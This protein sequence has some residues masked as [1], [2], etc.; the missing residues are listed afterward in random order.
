MDKKTIYLFF[1]EDSYTGNEKLKLWKKEFI[2]KYG[3]DGVEVFSESKF[4]SNSFATNIE[5]VPFLSEKKLII[6]KDF[7]AKAKKED[8]EKLSKAIE[9]TPDFCIL[10]F[11]E[12]GSID[13]RLGLYKKISK[14]GT[15][16]EFKEKNPSEI[17]SFILTKARREEIKISPLV[18]NYIST[19]CGSDLW[20][21]SNEIKKLKL[22]AQDKEVTT[23]MVDQLTT[24]SLS[25][26]V[27]KLT[28]TITEKDSRKALQILKTLDENGEELTKIFF[29]IVRHFRILIQV[30]D[31][32]Q[33]N[34]S[35]GTIQKRLKQHPFVIQ[36]TSTQSK[37]FTSQRLEEIYGKLLEIDKNFKT[38]VVRIQQGDNRAYSLA[39]EKL[40]IDCCR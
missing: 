18:A 16:E 5:A 36:K 4:D 28:D 40:I 22:F 39:I 29:M 7:F 11:Q 34:E 10:V 6:I 27:F 24:P 21:I 23:T 37:N 20:T 32:V 35:R 25:A 13:K 26:S 9:K 12:S 14:L 38:G 8:L 15:V 19:H 33:K 31:M 2:K 1:G 17:T 3:E 30:H